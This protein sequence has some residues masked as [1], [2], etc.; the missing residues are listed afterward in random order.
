MAINRESDNSNSDANH[1]RFI[2]RS[3]KNV[4][5]SSDSSEPPSSTVEISSAIPLTS[6]TPPQIPGDRPKILSSENSAR[7]YRRWWQAWQVW[8]VLLVLCSG[9]IGYGAT[10]MLIKLPETQ[11]CSKVFWPIASAAVRLYCAQTAAENKTVNGLLK[12]IDLVAVLPENHPLR[13]EIDRNIKKWAMSILEVGEEQFQQGEL[14]SAIA[15]A[16]QI[17]K[18]VEAHKLVEEKIAD[19]QEI[20]SQGEETYAQLEQ[21]L[22]DAKW[23]EAFSWAVRLTESKNAYWATTKYEE[24]IDKINIAQEENATVGKAQTQLSNGKIEDILL[25]IDKVDNIDKNS[26]A[27]EQAQKIIAEGKEKL[28]ANIEQL[29]EK[30]NWRELL[31][32]SNRIPYSLGWNDRVREWNILASAGSSADL[33][34][35]LGIEDAIEE[36]KKIEANSIYYK[37]AQQLI[38]RWTVEIDDV[39]HL[40]KARELARV[41]TIDNLQQAIAEANL[42]AASNP[43]YAEALKEIKQWRN[44][45]QIIED[46]PVLNRAQELAYGNNPDAWRRAIAEVKLIAPSSPLY[47]EAQNYSRTWRANIERT[48]DQP[49]LDRAIA[50]ADIKNY[51]AAIAEARKIASGRALSGDAQEKINLWEQEIKAEVYLREAN[52]LSN[53]GTPEALNRAI[54]IARQVATRSSLR[55]QVA[56]NVASWSWEILDLAQQASRTSLSRALA[57][58]EQVPSG[59]PAHSEAQIQMQR[60]REVLNP[61][62][63][64]IPPLPPS[65]KLEK[66]EKN[67][68]NNNDE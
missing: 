22:R 11:S 18:N 52:D 28:L 26:Y 32:V 44:K 58:A 1:E 40:S 20:W 45:I 64:E 60:W 23:N 37:T 41:G 4:S 57:I 68:E 36:A 61:P 25:A 7:P 13:P 39:R 53:L 35:V 27:Y 48:E 51:Q 30:R 49:I 19:W 33:D 47:G 24:S 59:T 8:G 29:I 62:E 9:G 12:A 34:T 6:S 14:Q 17:P 55:S 31:Q 66:Q 56:D 67:Q 3:Q 42:I 38:K 54:S 2:T 43:R 50:F 16:K 65:F 46:Q 5:Q 10:A 15:T 21:R 63:P